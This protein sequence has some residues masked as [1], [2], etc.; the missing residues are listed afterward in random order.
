MLL[1]HIRI[2]VFFT[3]STL[4]LV[5]HLAWVKVVEQQLQQM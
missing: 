2:K 5:H 4:D 3:F 1:T